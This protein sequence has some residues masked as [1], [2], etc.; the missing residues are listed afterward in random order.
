[1]IA[2]DNLC[3]GFWHEE[4]RRWVVALNDVCLNVAANEFVCVLGPSGSG[5]STLLNLIAGFGRPDSGRIVCDGREVDGPG[6]DRGVVFQE[7]TLFPW[8]T[9]S[10]N[11]EFGLRNLG[12]PPAE[13]R[14]VSREF[15]SRVGLEDF[16]DARPHEL[17]GGMRQR[18]ALAR[19]LA[20]EPMA[21]LLD[22]PFGALDAL[23]RDRL[24]DELIRIWGDD[25]KTVLFVTHNVEEAAYLADRVVLMGPAPRSVRGELVVPLRRPR[26]RTSVELREV[27]LTLAGELRDMPCCVPPNGLRDLDHIEGGRQSCTC[28]NAE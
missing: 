21:L 11:V 23:A 16:M 19:I 5:K 24:Q 12:L 10:R 28:S 1:M 18:V 9:A 7:H 25:R 20:M 17:S 8:L 4:T 15:L 3:K 13:R 22:E 26:D 2:I 6:P 14:A 27:V